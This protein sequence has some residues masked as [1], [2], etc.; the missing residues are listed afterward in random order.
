MHLHLVHNY[1]IKAKNDLFKISVRLKKPYRK[2]IEASFFQSHLLYYR[3]MSSR[4][5]KNDVKDVTI[6]EKIIP[7]DM[8]ICKPTEGKTSQKR[9]N[10]SKR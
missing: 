3:T 8:E 6:I 1:M 4:K 9:T 2:H 7:K 5:S 10:R